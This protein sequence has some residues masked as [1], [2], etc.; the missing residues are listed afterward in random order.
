MNA[1]DYGRDNR[2]RLWF[3]GVTDHRY[4]DNM[5]PNT[6]QEFYQLMEE[7]INNLKCMLKP[8]SPCI[9]IVG[10][11]KRKNNTINT[12]SIIQEIALSN[13]GFKILDILEDEIP[14]ARRARKEGNM[15]KKEWTVIMRKEG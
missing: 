10:E 12:S 11:V 2:L 3:L 8:K 1:L 15:T 9:F 14:Y 6:A 13:G 7:V 4:Y 5:S